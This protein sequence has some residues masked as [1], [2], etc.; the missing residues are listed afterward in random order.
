MERLRGGISIKILLIST[1]AL[2][3]PPVEYGGMEWVV[4]DLAVSLMLKGHKVSVAAAQGSKFPDG[5]E[6]I[7]TV[8]QGQY[9]FMEKEAL[10]AYQ[11][12]LDEF[13][14]I[15]DNSHFKLVFS[16]FRGYENKYNY[17]STLH[18]TVSIKYPIINPNLVCVSRSLAAYIDRLYHYNP[19][20]VL[21]ATDLSRYK[22][23]K[24]KSD[25]FL[26]LARP[27]PEKGALDAINFCKKLDV[28]IDVVAGRLAGDPIGYATDVARACT[29]GSKWV[30][31]GA[32][33]HDR[34][35]EFLTNAKALIFPLNWQEPF[36]LNI[37]EALASGTPVIA[38]KRASMKEIIIPGKTGFLPIGPKDFLDSMRKVDQIKPEDCRA[39]AEKRWHRDRM[40]DDYLKL[41]DL[42]RSGERW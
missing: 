26:F 39:D 28:P 22:Y 1:A 4:Y 18:T 36:G 12:R 41:Y 37:I 38:Y 25:R 40:A 32:I 8:K 30:Y 17:L 42:V 20:A 2:P 33:S 27:N 21:N 19:K 16:L 9:G 14:I 10:R 31:H 5:I 35:Y 29:W 11:S 6:L 7:E 24:E 3:T 15:H 34:K 23:S 13:D